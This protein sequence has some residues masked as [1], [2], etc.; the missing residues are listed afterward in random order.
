M[1]SKV[2]MIVEAAN[3]STCGAT[4]ACDD[5]ITREGLTICD[6][7]AVKLGYVDAL[8]EETKLLRKT[9]RTGF[10]RALKTGVFQRE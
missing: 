7:C 3:C 5:Y 2:S 6:K 4:I 1:S 10:R 9:K 8:A